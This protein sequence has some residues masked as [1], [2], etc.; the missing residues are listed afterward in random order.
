MTAFSSD[1]RPLPS[2]SLT[3][4]RFGVVLAGIVLAAVVLRVLPAFEYGQDWYGRGSFTLVNF[5]EGGS[6][7]AALGGFPYSPLVGA[8]T[9]TLAALGGHEAPTEAYADA[10]IAKAFCHSE[11]HLITARLYSAT[12]GGLTVGVIALLS[13]QLFPRRYGLA[14]GAAA[15]LGLSGWHISESMVGTVDAP[16][17]FFI[18]LFLL[19]AVLALRRG[20]IAW[21]GAGVALVFAVGTKYWVFAL[22]ALAALVPPAAYRRVLAG[23]AVRRGVLLLGAYALL[24]GLVSNPAAG[25]LLRWLLPLGWLALVPWQRLSVSGR[26]CLFAAPWLAPLAMYCESFVAYASGYP[27]G[28]FGTDYGAIGWYR[29]LRNPVNLPLVLVMGLGLPAFGLFCRGVRVL[30]KERSLDRAWLALLPLLAFALYMAFLAPVTY[31]RHYLP[32]LPAAAMLAALGACSLA[33][34]PSVLWSVVLVWQALLAGDLVSDYHYDPRR[35]LVGW[36]AQHQPQR[37]LTSFYVNPPP[38][39]AAAHRL[40]RVPYASDRRLAWADTV[41]LSENWYDTAFA[42]ELNGP[43]VGDPWHLIKTTPEA[44]AFY[45]AALAGEHPR[46]EHLATLRAPTFMPELRAH[47]FFYGSFTQFVGDL[48]LFRV[49]P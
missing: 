40:F 10:R 48:Q 23:L 22:V 47:H 18:Y 27:E 17:T 13:L 45:R 16:S 12:L 1:P 8:Q 3:L 9:L 6:C 2:S 29:L 30:T 19:L 14:L 34:R 25:P 35:D 21:L 41:I 49:R 43:L 42:N 32:L 5:D 24:F 7:R 26:I 46:L 38:A 37:V 39:S 36:Y 11:A 44:V 33:W 31:Y 28:R 15:L 20:G 4:A